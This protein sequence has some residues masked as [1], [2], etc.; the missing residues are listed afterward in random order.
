MYPHSRTNPRNCVMRSR[1]TAYNV[2]ARQ[3]S[4]STNARPAGFQ[5]VHASTS[6]ICLVYLWLG[7][8]SVIVDCFG[9]RSCSKSWRSGRGRRRSAHACARSDASVCIRWAGCICDLK[10]VFG[11]SPGSGHRLALQRVGLHDG[12]C[13]ERAGFALS[14]RR[15]G[16]ITSG[17]AAGEHG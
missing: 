2:E 17:E 15:R 7:A 8:R 9:R 10:G 16:Y 5:H 1:A 4:P 13:Q 6:K 11:A 3:K 14:G 12:L